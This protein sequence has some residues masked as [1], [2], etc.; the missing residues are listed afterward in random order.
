[1][2]RLARA[3][4]TIA[5]ITLCVIP[6][7]TQDHIA[8]LG[9]TQTRAKEAIFDSFMANTLSLAG[10][11]DVFKAATPQMRAAMV[12]AI[13]TLGRAFVESADFKQRYADHR[14]ANGPDPL[15]A[16][17]TVEQI[18]KKQRDDYEQQVAGIRA[19]YDQITPEQRKTLEIGFDEMRAKFDVIEKEG[20]AE[21][22][23]SLKSQRGPLVQAHDQAMKEF[24]KVFPA[25]S[26][27][28]V[29]NRLR[30]F[31]DLSRDVDFTAQLTDRNGKKV[32]AD[33]TL[34]ARPA[35][36]KMLFRAGKPATDAARAFAQKWLAELEG[37]G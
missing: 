25:D 10:K 2:S 37:K 7:A 14:E 27:L 21:L 26:K 9:I 1:M 19:M 30:R 29:A 5:L 11:A 8:A 13:A 12:T 17:Q 36:W 31:L 3:A 23:A 35:E 6:A 20:R 16:E 22:E 15:P 34:E 24:E 18:Y 4:I 28:L 33:P 32:F